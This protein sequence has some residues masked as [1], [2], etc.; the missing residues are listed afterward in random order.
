MGEKD[1]MEK[2]LE[3]YN[4]VFA[5]IVNVLLFDGEQV[6]KEDSLD[7]A[8]ARYHYKADLGR[9]HEMERDALKYWKD[10]GIRIAF[11]GL[12][13]Q[14]VAEKYM[15]LRCIG[16]DGAEYRRQLIKEYKTVN[17]PDNGEEKKVSVRRTPCP[18]VTLVL[19][20]GFEERW[21][22]PVNLCGC[23][24]VPERLKPFVN[25]YEMNLFE[26]AFLP[27]ETVGK[28]KS[29]FR[30]IVDYLVQM[31]K[32]GTYTGSDENIRHVHEVLEL[33]SVVTN[34]SNIKYVLEHHESEVKTMKNAF[35]IFGDK[36]KMEGK[37]EGKLEGETVILKMN[38]YLIKNERWEDLKRA[39][40]DEDFR[41]EILRQMRESR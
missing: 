10:S 36:K 25:D 17:D 34:S 11:F 22:E 8:I 19:Y 13:N 20:F 32:T 26:L 27:D 33:L 31:R 37:I 30:F 24:Q 15:P 41:E 3:T 2:T 28:F 35:D 1:I 7:D 16:Y 18:V 40:E 38:Q 14:T 21:S 6:V 9:L 29:D 4:D 23:I 39:T 12:E 5:D